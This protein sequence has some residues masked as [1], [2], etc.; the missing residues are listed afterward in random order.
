MAKKKKE[1]VTLTKSENIL[2]GNTVDTEK[3]KTD[4][5]KYVD[6]RINKVF[7]DELDKAN[8]KLLRE[9]SKKIFVKNIVII[10]LLLIIGFLLYLLFSNNYFDHYFN[11]N[12]K[13]TQ[14]KEDIKKDDEEKKEEKEEEKKEEKKPTLAELKKEYSHLLDSYVISEKC[15][16]LED[17]YNG[18]LTSNLKQYLTL[19]TLNFDTLKKEDDF[20]I[21]LNDTFKLA[22]GRLFDGEYS[23][24]SFDYNGNTIRYVNMMNS[25]MTT[26]LLKKDDSSIR[27]EISDIKVE[28]D[29][30][31][32]TTIEG[33]VKDHK[34]YNIVYN[35]EIENYKDDS[36]L[37]YSDELNKVI[38]T[39]TD[40]KLS[41][42]SK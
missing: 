35:N 39:F 36:L 26:S 9:K 1:E 31:L 4:L 10:I 40:S 32:I 8:R 27:R 23:N 42:L 14:V 13:E 30:V 17:Y 15:L 41:D 12:D 20:Q 7:I 21:I 37:K 11:K 6:E 24:S 34:L 28:D 33:L 16:Y 29:K 2:L 25:Y 18:N 38:Y 19:N 22:Y 5:E 3:V